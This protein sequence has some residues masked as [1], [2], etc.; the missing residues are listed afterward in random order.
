MGCGE[1]GDDDDDK[2]CQRSQD[3]GRDRD[4]DRD[5][6]HD[7]D[8]DHSDADGAAS[9]VS[10]TPSLRLLSPPPR[11]FF[12]RPPAPP[13]LC[14]GW[15]PAAPPR[16]SFLHPR[17]APPRHHEQ[18]DTFRQQLR[19]AMWRCLV[20]NWMREAGTDGACRS[21]LC[22]PDPAALA[23]RASRQRTQG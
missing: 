20:G 3:H 4:R 15:P 10:L 16:H 2:T 6:D 23:R 18:E 19:P 13:S 8:R 21:L 7:H 12:A 1:V 9:F 14:R 11:R 5:R 17:C 22:A